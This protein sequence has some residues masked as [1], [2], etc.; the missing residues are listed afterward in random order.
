MYIIG[1]YV[2]VGFP[3]WGFGGRTY[4]LCMRVQAIMGDNLV[5]NWVKK[6]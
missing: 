4:I 1:G 5:R 6:T 2:C 3:P